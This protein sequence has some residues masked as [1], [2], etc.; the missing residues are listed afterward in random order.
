MQRFRRGAEENGT[1]RPHA[2]PRHPFAWICPSCGKDHP[3]WLTRRA[4][5]EGRVAEKLICGCGWTDDVVLEGWTHP[6]HAKPDPPLVMPVRRQMRHYCGHAIDIGAAS[7]DAH[8]R[9]PRITRGHW[10]PSCGRHGWNHEWRWVEDGKVVGEGAHGLVLR[11]SDLTAE[12]RRLVET[13]CPIPPEI[14]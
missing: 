5:A 7:A 3:A 8:A 4:D 11:Y 12:G 2:D 10:C 13:H 9:D 6:E 14:L 1:W